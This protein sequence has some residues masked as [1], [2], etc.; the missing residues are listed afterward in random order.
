MSTILCLNK[1]GIK[2]YGYVYQIGDIKIEKIN[3]KYIEKNPLRCPDKNKFKQMS[4]IIDTV[5]REGDSI[6]GV[7]EVRTIGLPAGLGSPVFNKIDA[8][9][10]TPKE[11]DDLTPILHENISL[12]E[13]QKT[14]IAKS[15]GESMFISALNKTH[16]DDL[17]DVLY[18][19][20]K[21]LHEVR[22]PYNNFLY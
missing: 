20:I 7:I 11:E 13:Y 16:L 4:S 8:Y 21:Q 17:K 14:W 3:L 22:Y 5:R 6:G 12:E 19:K 18:D 10:F 2:T 9:A 15:N 1:I